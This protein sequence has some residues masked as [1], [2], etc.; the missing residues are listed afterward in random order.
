M[1][2][3]PS[4]CYGSETSTYPCLFE[5]T[6][7]DV[8]DCSDGRE[9]KSQTQKKVL[10]GST[11]VEPTRSVS[12]TRNLCDVAS[13]GS[14]RLNLV[15]KWKDLLGNIHTISQR[16]NNNAYFDVT[17]QVITYMDNQFTMDGAMVFK[18]ENQG[19]PIKYCRVYTYPKLRLDCG[20]NTQNG[21]N[22]KSPGFTQ[23]FYMGVQPINN[24]PLPTKAGVDCTKQSTNINCNNVSDYA[25]YCSEATKTMPSWYKDFKK[26]CVLK[27]QAT[28]SNDYGY[29]QSWLSVNDIAFPSK[30]TVDCSKQDAN[31]CTQMGTLAKQCAYFTDKS[32]QDYANAAV[33]CINAKQQ[34]LTTPISNAQYQELLQFLSSNSINIPIPNYPSCQYLSPSTLWTGISCIGTEADQKTLQQYAEYAKQTVLNNLSKYASDPDYPKLV[35]AFKK[36]NITLPTLP[37]PNVDCSDAAAQGLNSNN[38]NFVDTYAKDCSAYDVS[39]GKTPRAASFYKEYAKQCKVQPNNYGNETK[40][41]SLQTF[42]K[43]KGLYFPDYPLSDPC[44]TSASTTNTPGDHYLVCKEAGITSDADSVYIQRAMS[45]R[46]P[47]G[48]SDDQY[49]KLSTY[50]NKPWTVVKT[51]WYGPYGGTWVE[52]AQTTLEEAKYICD[53]LGYDIFC[54]NPALTS[55]NFFAAKSSAV[56][57]NSGAPSTGWTFYQRKALATPVL[58]AIP[59]VDCAGETN[60]CDNL[61]AF[62]KQC[63]TFTGKKLEYYAQKAVDCLN[64]KYGNQVTA[65]SN[66]YDPRTCIV[67]SVIDTAGYDAAKNTLSSKGVTAPA[68]SDVI[69]CNKQ[70]AAVPSDFCKKPNEYASLCPTLPYTS[71]NTVQGYVDSYK[72]KCVMFSNS[73]DST[74]YTNFRNLAISKGI[75]T[76]ATT[77]G[78]NTDCS[79]VAIFNPDVFSCNNLLSKA[80][81]CT[82]QTNLQ[83]ADFATTCYW[84]YP[85]YTDATDYNNL[86]TFL[87]GKGIGIPDWTNDAACEPT[88]VAD[89]LYKHYV[90]CKAKLGLTDANYVTF[91]MNYFNNKS[92]IPGFGQS[93]DASIAQYN[94]LRT[95]LL[96]KNL[97]IPPIPTK[98][99]ECLSPVVTTDPTYMRTISNNLYGFYMFCNFTKTDQPFIDFAKAAIAINMHTEVVNPGNSGR[100]IVQYNMFRDYLKNIKNITIDALPAASYDSRIVSNCSDVDSVVCS[101]YS[102]V[103]ACILDKVQKVAN[104]ATVASVLDTSTKTITTTPYKYILASDGTYRGVRKVAISQGTK[105]CSA[106]DDT[107]QLA[108]ASVPNMQAILDFSNA[109]Y[110]RAGFTSMSACVLDILNNK[111]KTIP[112]GYAS[113]TSSSSSACTYSSAQPS[114]GQRTVTTTTIGGWDYTN[115][116][117]ISDSTSSVVVDCD[118]CTNGRCNLPLNTI[119]CNNVY[120]RVRYASADACIG[121]LVNG[122]KPLPG[123]ADFSSNTVTNA[124]L[125]NAAQPSKGQQTTTTN[126][127]SGWDYAKN[128]FVPNSVTTSAPQNCDPCGGGTKCNLSR[129]SNFCTNLFS[130]AGYASADDC[131]TKMVNNKS[132]I[133]SGMDPVPT[134][135]ASDCKYNSTMPSLGSKTITTNKTAGWDYTNGVFVPPSTTSVAQDCNPWRG[136]DSIS[137]DTAFCDK[138]YSQA[139]FASKDA[140]IGDL[141]NNARTIGSYYGNRFAPTVTSSVGTCNYN[142]SLPSKGG[143]T[144][145]TNY[146]SGWDL[147]SNTFKNATSSTSTQDCDPCASTSPMTLECYKKI[148][149]NAGCKTD[150]SVNY[151][152][153]QNQSYQTLVN[154]SAA[155]ATVPDKVHVEGCYGPGT[156]PRYARPA[157]ADQGYG[158]QAGRLPRGWYDIIGQGVANDYCRYV[159]YNDP[160]TDWAC[161]LSGLTQ[162]ATSKYGNNTVYANTYNGK[163]LR[164]VSDMPCTYKEIVTQDCASDGSVANRVYRGEKVGGNNSCASTTTRT[165]SCP[166]PDSRKERDGNGNCVWK[167]CPFD[168]NDPNTVYGM[169]RNANG[170]CECPASDPIILDWAKECGWSSSTKMCVDQTT[171]DNAWRDCYDGG[172]Q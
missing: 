7:T 100:F 76:L 88:P 108:S 95:A 32:M 9:N 110:T 47:G 154:D 56:D 25:I 163:D 150:P 97:Y 85:K 111:N 89:D 115:N 103:D 51:N 30:P 129:L 81:N 167:P 147:A 15:G 82:S 24:C 72:N 102:G 18:L 166:C 133:P 128:V 134:V 45:V 91:A 169:Q 122:A 59:S 4:I 49:N 151:W 94:L 121:D 46:Q 13:D 33:N 20:Y 112:A 92:Y 8:D 55:Y 120:S 11:C 52:A 105:T 22:D 164:F 79:N 148:W 101:G 99:T 65:C 124:C 60:I 118:P 170:D 77:P 106:A 39:I 114:K 1:S 116:R 38:C 125:Y 54:Y 146:T 57:V 137:T 70:Y 12:C 23:Y 48:I 90:K 78:G 10:G 136:G 145:T 159:G 26:Q 157:M 138:L 161:H 61:D 75:N 143:K 160:N 109:F 135:S 153:A 53:K 149:A 126:V 6:W 141:V 37:S 162:G 168:W 152:W 43:S 139:G 130:R 104:G 132:S 2:V 158:D 21:W 35:D 117:V 80:Q 50:L 28:D 142:S 156:W 71:G 19:Q 40:W 3:S 64:T 62:V 165:E 69:K 36:V 87:N 34:D 68:S 5:S 31:M 74:S 84:N 42:I 98:P 73:T 44:T 119:F 171:K 93:A 67:N 66:T 83:A 131:M 96:A 17:S 86:Q 127:S 107:T 63:P 172:W 16:V 29:L 27:N 123:G 58:P 41:K 14:K 144:V 155:W 140:C 113:L